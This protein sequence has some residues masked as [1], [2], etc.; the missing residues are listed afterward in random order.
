MS[1][2]GHFRTS[3]LAPAMSAAP[4][5]ADIQRHD[6][7]VRFVP[8]AEVARIIRSTQRGMSPDHRSLFR[9]GPKDVD[10]RAQ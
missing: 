8:E 3:T 7:D 9:N 10:S 1:E 4:P 5:E 2:V 6:G